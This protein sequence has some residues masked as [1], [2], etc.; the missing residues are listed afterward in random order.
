MCS[1][2]AAQKDS[3][4]P[5]GPACHRLSRQLQRVV[6]G[7][8]MYTQRLMLKVHVDNYIRFRMTMVTVGGG[9]GDTG[10]R[11]GLNVPGRFHEA[12]GRVEA[13]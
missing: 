2:Q 10:F 12:S 11:G 5:E 13:W 1:V 4:H 8:L 3:K 9:P 7:T 6:L